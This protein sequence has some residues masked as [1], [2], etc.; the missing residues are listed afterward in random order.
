MIKEQDISESTMDK[1]STYS[2][3]LLYITDTY[4]QWMDTTTEILF[5]GK[6]NLYIYITIQTLHTLR[7]ILTN[8]TL[9]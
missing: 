7:D 3:P 2:I 9:L 1:K 6:L 5:L 4:K 8:K